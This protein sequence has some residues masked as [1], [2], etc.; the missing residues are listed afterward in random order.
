VPK[1]T[2]QPKISSNFQPVPT[3]FEKKQLDLKF[4]RAFFS[5]NFTFRSADNKYLRGFCEALRPGY[6]PPNRK[7]LSGELLDALNDEVDA[8]MLKELSDI[9]EYSALAISQDG[10]SNVHNEPLLVSNL[11]FDKK[12]NLLRSVECGSKKKTAE[13]CAKQAEVDINKV[14]EHYGKQVL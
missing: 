13:Y 12:A 2:K 10:W 5:C 9:P 3:G 7:E 6:E 11:I 8:E 1:I 4:A 14:A